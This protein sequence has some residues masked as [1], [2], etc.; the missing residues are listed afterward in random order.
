MV[1]AVTL[2]LFGLAPFWHGG[3]TWQLLLFYALGFGGTILGC[4]ASR[5]SAGA[6]GWIL[7]F[8]IGHAYALYTWFLWPVLVRSVL[9]QMANRQDWSKTDREPLETATGIH[10]PKPAIPVSTTSNP[11]LQDAELH[12]S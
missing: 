2:A 8:L 7:G 9:R 4:V 3:P 12:V 11:A 5:R 1:A 10:E 6:R